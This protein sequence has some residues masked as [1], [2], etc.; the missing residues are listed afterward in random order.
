MYRLVLALVLLLSTFGVSLVHAEDAVRVATFDLTSDWPRGIQVHLVADSVSDITAVTA[1]VT[2]GKALASS[3]QK[4]DIAPAKSIDTT[5]NVSSGGATPFADISVQIILD[6][7]AG[8][9]IRTQT[10]TIEYVDQRY[11]WNRKTE[12]NLTAYWH[13]LPEAD[14]TAILHSAADALERIDKEAGLRFS[15]PVKLVIYNDQE[16]MNSVTPIRSQRSRQ[17]LVFLGMAYDEFDVVLIKAGSQAKETAAH[18]ITHLVSMHTAENPYL[19]LPVWLNEGLSVYFEGDNGVEYAGLFRAARRGHRL[20]SIRGMTTLPGKSDDALLVYGEGYE[21]VK[22][23]IQTYGPEKMAAYLRAYRTA[24][25]YDEPLRAT[26]GFDRDGLEKAW[27]ASVYGTSS[28]P[29]QPPVSA[30]QNRTKLAIV[31]GVF[32]GVGLLVLFAGGAFAAAILWARRRTS[33]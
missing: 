16:E 1:S 22:Y 27:L 21:I 32:M 7:K 26:Y 2:F 29:Q 24:V 28:S 20:L 13:V 8:D 5:F 10:K 30:A 9:R 3:L 31:T 4:Q 33:G 17:E 12:G 18:E 14:A 25:N 19:P 15:D 6:T 23:L 11:Q